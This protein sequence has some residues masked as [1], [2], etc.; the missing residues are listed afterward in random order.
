M[1]EIKNIII[2]EATRYPGSPNGEYMEAVEGGGEWEGECPPSLSRVG[3][4]SR[5]LG[6]ENDCKCRSYFFSFVISIT[7]S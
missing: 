2:P 5:D 7:K 1:L 4:D 6:K 3:D